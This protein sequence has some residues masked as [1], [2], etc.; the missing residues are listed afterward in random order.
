M[1]QSSFWSCHFS[2]NF[3][4]GY[5]WPMIF[6][7]CMHVVQ[8]CHPCQIF[9]HKMCS[10]PAPLH[11]VVVVDPF[12][13]WGIDFMTCNPTSTNGHGYIIVVVDYFT[14]WFKDFPT[15]SNDGIAVAFSCST[16]STRFDVPRTIIM[17]PWVPLPQ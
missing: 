3:C 12:S 14:K 8:K 4:A 2:E 17:E 11:P 5:F 16:T 1:W 6:K 13:K 10:H 7:D 15:F 9:T